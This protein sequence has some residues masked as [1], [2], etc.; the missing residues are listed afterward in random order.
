MSVSMNNVSSTMTDY[1]NLR[2][3]PA[4]AGVF[5]AVLTIFQFGGLADVTITWFDYTLTQNHALYGSLLMW[6]VAFAGSETRQFENYEEVEQGTIASGLGLIA[7]YHISP[8]VNELV[9]SSPLTQMIATGTVL[10]AWAV[11]VQ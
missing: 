5:F 11:S 6:F 7:L 2:T 3:I 4:L 1:A 10:T 8:Q 9:M